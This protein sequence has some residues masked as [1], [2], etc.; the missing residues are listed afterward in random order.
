MDSE[1]AQMSIRDD[2]RF[3]W[4]VRR[5]HNRMI[6]LKNVTKSYPAREKKITAA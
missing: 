1:S 6:R 2:A 5:T 4:R 3:G